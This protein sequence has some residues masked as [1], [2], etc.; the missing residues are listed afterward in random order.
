LGR[1]VLGFIGRFRNLLL[2]ILSIAVIA[3]LA[4]FSGG[5]PGARADIT[6]D[7]YVSPTDTSLDGSDVTVS[8]GAT[9]TVD[10]THSLGTV[11][12]QKGSK[13]TTSPAGAYRKLSRS[14]D[15]QSFYGHAWLIKA[16]GYYV[17]PTASAIGYVFKFPNNS[18]S[19]AAVFRIKVGE[20]WKQVC[21]SSSDYYTGSW[22]WNQGG[23]G[24]CPAT[25]AT[26][27]VGNLTAGQS[28]QMELYVVQSKIAK[29]RTPSDSST[30][31]M[32][33]SIDGG[34]DA[35]IVINNEIKSATSQNQAALDLEFFSST[36]DKIAYSADM[37]FPGTNSLVSLADYRLF[38]VN[39][40]FPK[41]QGP[42]QSGSIWYT[43]RSYDSNGYISAAS[44]DNEK[45][46]SPLN[47]SVSASTTCSTSSP[48]N[49]ELDFSTGSDATSYRYVTYRYLNPLGYLSV[50]WANF[51]DDFES[52]YTGFYTKDVLSKLDNLPPLVINAD[53]LTVND[54]GAIDVSGKGYMGGRG[55]LSSDGTD[56]T[57]V[58]TK[59]AISGW[60]DRSF[61][62]TYAPAFAGFGAG[63]GEGY[64]YN[65][66]G[67]I[68]IN[69]GGGGYGGHGGWIPSNMTG[70]IT[71][72]NL[73]VAAG[74]TYSVSDNAS[75]PGSG[76]GVGY[77]Y[78]IAGATDPNKYMSGGNGGGQ[79]KLNVGI[80]EMN[81]LAKIAA[82]GTVACTPSGGSCNFNGV[83]LE[84]EYTTS[85][86]MAGAG[87]G[88]SI[89]LTVTDSVSWNVSP[90]SQAISAEGGGWW[91]VHDSPNVLNGNNNYQGSGGGGGRVVLS[92]PASE[93]NT[94]SSNTSVEARCYSPADNNGQCGEDGTL[95]IDSSNGLVSPIVVK[96]TYSDSVYSK[97]QATFE[98]GQTVFVELEVDELGTL[99][100][101]YKI[102]DH[103]PSG[104]TKK[105][106]SYNFYSA[107]NLGGTPT[108][109]KISVGSD[110]KITINGN[111]TDLQLKQGKNLFRY[112]YTI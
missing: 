82:D 35:S 6:S 101:D 64:S 99:R 109:V 85:F 71:T 60:G 59:P 103:I 57:N 97:L 9:L 67:R 11:T 10:G 50:D 18:V 12:V 79:I 21:S 105:P 88:G 24:S 31:T 49:F 47:Q 68:L 45:E 43:S 56:A 58:Q 66:N 30:L 62:Y 4:L 106:T 27:S 72:R 15:R 75:L 23:Y 14:L 17:A 87:S 86:I 32:K 112:S 44:T 20:T 107:S 7:R 26:V 98:A 53:K 8:N 22:H 29:S 51:G 36:K 37:S 69:G 54:G 102:E 61:T 63:G 81:G 65:R 76:G 80:L 19:D 93:V 48:C 90:S 46:H 70:V 96:T 2:V 42:T 1:S 38:D 25:G 104:V 34:A 108:E 83:S 13:V 55:K 111:N 89:D 100:S 41:T 52:N 73:P 74:A 77:G 28:Y 33:R 5:K 92:L 39:P 78:D 91:Y 94:V 40:Y 110:N 84:D 95:T 3:S 16:T